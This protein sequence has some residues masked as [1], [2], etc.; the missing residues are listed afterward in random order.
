MLHDILSQYL[1]DI[2]DSI[3]KLESVNVENSD[4]PLILNVIEEAKLLAK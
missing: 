1:S 3:R 2:E 4:E